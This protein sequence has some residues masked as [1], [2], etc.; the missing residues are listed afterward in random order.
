MQ[1]CDL[2]CPPGVQRDAYGRCVYIAPYAVNQTFRRPGTEAV[3]A[4]PIAPIPPAPRIVR[5]IEPRNM[6]TPRPMPS[7]RLWPGTP[8]PYVLLSGA[9]GQT[10]T[11]PLSIGQAKAALFAWSKSPG[12][13][14]PLSNYGTSL[15]DVNQNWTSRDG[16]MLH[17]FS[18]WWNATHSNQLPLGTGSIASA[19]LTAAHVVALQTFGAAQIPSGFIP[20]PLTVPTPAQGQ[21]QAQCAL[22]CEQKYGVTSGALNQSALLTC[23]S[24]CAQGQ[25]VTPPTQPTLP[26]PPTQPTLPPAK[27]ETKSNTALWVVGGLA[28]A[29][30]VGVTLM[31]KKS[32]ASNPRG[33]KMLSHMR[34]K[35]YGNG[36]S[37]RYSKANNA[38]FIMW[39][40]QVLGVANTYHGADERARELVN[41]TF[42]RTAR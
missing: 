38:W 24:A 34:N 31:S 21:A 37:I 30:I 8:M 17:G 39:N 40:D 2:A 41:K 28:A 29:A 11:D 12:V 22:T 25:P 13:S 18:V 42:A 14:P 35:S 10:V 32:L 36:V 7:Q 20:P 26:P 33:R 4:L 27:T 16:I 6:P 15:E 9:L 23:L 19:E 3:F 1:R 5:W